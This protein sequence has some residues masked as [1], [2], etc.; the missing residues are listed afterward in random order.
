MTMA[1]KVG[2]IIAAATPQWPKDTPREYHGVTRGWIVN[3][4]IR[5][6]DPSGR[7]VAA[8][9][10]EDICPS[11]DLEK[12]LRLGFVDREDQVGELIWLVG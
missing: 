2:E 10:R 6:A 12:N 1:L 3:E 7:T 9:L 4:V 11:L 5:R 8:I